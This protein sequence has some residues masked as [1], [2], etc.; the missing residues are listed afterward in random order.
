VMYCNQ[1]H[2]SRYVMV[3]LYGSDQSFFVVDLVLLLLLLLS[4]ANYVAWYMSPI[5][6]G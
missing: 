4:N 1:G 2:E 5:I 6:S 3:C